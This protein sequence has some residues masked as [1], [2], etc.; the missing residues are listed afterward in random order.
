MYILYKKQKIF[1]QKSLLIFKFLIYIMLVIFFK[2]EDLMKKLFSLI[3]VSLLTALTFAGC[4]VEENPSSSTTTSVESVTTSKVT[5]SKPTSSAK[6]QSSSS[7]K[8]KSSSK[9]AT[10][11]KKQPKYT[12][13]QKVLYG[14]DPDLYS[15]SLKDEGNPARIAALMKKAQKGGSYK[16]AVFGG[17]ISQG[18]G[19]SSTYSSYG[20][21][22]CD[23]WYSNFPNADFEFVNGGLGSTNPEMACYRIEEDLLKFKPDFVVVDF[24]VNSSNDNDAYNTL[25]T[26]LYKILSQENSPAVMSIDFTNCQQGANY[27]KKPTGNIK[28]DW[29]NAIKAYN[30]PAMSYNKYV[31]SKIDKNIISWYDIGS[32]YIHPNDNGHMIAAN[33][34]TCYLEKIMNNLSKQSTKITAPTKPETSKYLNLGYVTN[35]AKNVKLSGGFTARKNTSPA[36][37]GWSY[38]FTKDPSS[39]TVPIPANKSVEVFIEFDDDAEGSITITDNNQNTK[40]ISSSEAKYPTL[41]NIG[42]KSGSITITP[43]MQYGGFRI[44]GI[45]IN[46]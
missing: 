39:L 19:A 23:W 29:T 27:G 6:K 37:R 21:L 22:V 38:T 11:S 34:I 44:F 42:S 28:A 26:I 17:S 41:V 25:C 16:I 31:W 14:L 45:G 7:K 24:S 43:N 36:T 10:S 46:K 15:L 13:K 3:L 18:A 8:K 30:I 33:I 40:T 35:A 4:G 1:W 32:D 5:T 9:V 12:K 2:G 20:S